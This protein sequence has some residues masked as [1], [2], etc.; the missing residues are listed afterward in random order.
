MKEHLVQVGVI[1]GARGIR[2]EVWIS[3]YTAD[4]AA[5]AAYG[6]LFDAAGCNPLKLR[7]VQAAAGGRV[8]ARI[9]GVA[10]RADA[11]ALTGRA[12]FVPRPV[13]PEPAEDEF[14]HAD[15]IGLR[16]SDETGEPVGL[17]IALH[18]HGAG[19][20][21]EIAPADAPSFMLPFNR[22]AVPRIDVA[23]GEIV[24]ALPEGWLDEG[25]PPADPTQNENADAPAEMAAAEA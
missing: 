21:I 5:I 14:Y 13:F 15:L 7:I 24:V 3:S 18:N 23:A 4:P 16:A 6:P 20:M 10:D 22:K 1:T 8:A 12:L 17:V 11:E 2:G 19:D 25:A 9:E